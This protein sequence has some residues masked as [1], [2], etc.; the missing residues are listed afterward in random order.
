MP[1]KSEPLAI[2]GLGMV[3]SLGLGV[4]TSCAAAR[5][6]LSRA[7]ELDYTVVNTEDNQPEP[8]MGHAVPSMTRGF[9]GVGRMLRLGQLAFEDFRKSMNVNVDEINP[10]RCG[11]LLVLP[12]PDRSSRA[13]GEEEGK[14]RAEHINPL[15]KSAKE[16]C[17]TEEIIARFRQVTGFQAGERNAVIIYSGNAGLAIALDRATGRLQTGEWE[18]CIIGALDSLVEPPVLQWLFDQ[19]RL[20]CADNPVGMQPGE[21]GVFILLEQ[22]SRAVRRRA[23]IHGLLCA[24]ATC[25]EDNHLFTGK[26]SSGKGFAKAIGQLRQILDTGIEPFW[27]ISDLNGEVYRSMEFGIVRVRLAPEIPSF[28]NAKSLYPA[29][30]FGDTGSAGAAVS[31]CMVLR[32]FARDYAPS[33]NALILSSADSGERGAVYVQKLLS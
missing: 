9:E 15:L 30:S 17:D 13:I 6:G 27:L 32:A 22:K 7:T 23:A 18:S 21:A 25:F 33:H 5:G 31:L 29:I 11:L 24:S 28:R 16:P 1:K 10:A 3:S 19:G 26:P 20:K 2:T 12:D 14:K 4:V 8:V